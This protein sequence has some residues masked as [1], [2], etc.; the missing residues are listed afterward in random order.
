VVKLAIMV[1]IVVIGMMMVMVVV[2][3]DRMPSVAARAHVFE[4]LE[5]LVVHHRVVD[6]E[7]KVLVLVIRARARY[8]L[9]ALSTKTPE[10]GARRPVGVRPAQVLRGWRP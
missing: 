2:T 6:L 8:V 5:A 10:T 4:P 7:V 3:A 1:V 9:K